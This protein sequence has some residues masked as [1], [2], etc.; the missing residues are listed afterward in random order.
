MGFAKLEWSGGDLLS[1]AHAHFS[2][3]P[4]PSALMP[5]SG[6]IVS[7]WRHMLRNSFYS[8]AIGALSSAQ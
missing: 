8:L 7:R 2:V 6:M 5:A 1:V 3:F 4:H